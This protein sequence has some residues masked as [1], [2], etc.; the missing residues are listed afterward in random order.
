MRV[1]EYRPLVPVA[2][3]DYLASTLAFLIGFYLM[4]RGVR[5]IRTYAVVPGRPSLDRIILWSYGLIL[6]SLAAVFAWY[7][8]P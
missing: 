2:D 4:W 8:V 6:C 5:F 1:P 3:H 7:G